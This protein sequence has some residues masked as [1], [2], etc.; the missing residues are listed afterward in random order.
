[1][2][3]KQAVDLLEY[4]MKKLS[5]C[6]CVF[7]CV[8]IGKIS[9]EDYVNDLVE[10]VYVINLDHNPERFEYVKKQF[11]KMGIAIQ[12]FSAVDGKTLELIDESTGEKFNV[13]DASN[14]DFYIKHRNKEFLVV[15][16]N[17]KKELADAEFTYFSDQKLTFGEL[18]CFMSHRAIYAD[19][20]KKGYSNVIVF[21]DDVKILSER[22]KDDVCRILKNIPENTDL[23]FLDL[24]IERNSIKYFLDRIFSFNKNFI[25]K[26]R[27]SSNISGTHAYIVTNKGA[28]KLLR[29]TSFSN[30]PIDI[31][32]LF[33][34]TV[35][36][37]VSKTKLCTAGEIGS[38][39]ENFG[40]RN[41]GY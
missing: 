12:R 15:C 31:C 27:Y 28:R 24:H 40:K 14:A 7:L 13:Q 39:I 25:F 21:E 38:V 33:D 32:I 2:Y 9:A 34:R 35:K 19:I 17:R 20:V 6:L 23:V 10:A 11:D 30:I 18:G 16:E 41:Q 3:N 26:I 4:N 36:F 8:L 37:Y 22:F 1:M 29:R 5:T